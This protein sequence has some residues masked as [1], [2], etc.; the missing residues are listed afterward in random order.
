MSS[1][2]KKKHS[3]RS[4][5]LG[6]RE[7][8]HAASGILFGNMNLKRS[9]LGRCE[10]WGMTPSLWVPVV[11]TLGFVVD[12]LR[13]NLQPD[14]PFMQAMS[15]L[16]PDARVVPPGSHRFKR[17]TRYGSCNSSIFA[18]E[19]ALPALNSF[20]WRH[21]RAPVLFIQES[22]SFLVP[23][24]W[25]LRSHAF[26]HSTLGGAT[27][28]TSR[29]GILMPVEFD[30]QPSGVPSVVPRPWST[31]AHSV[32]PRIAAT[33]VPAP[34]APSTEPFQAVCAVPPAAVGSWGLF[35]SNQ[36]EVDVVLP[37]DKGWGRRPLTPRELSN[38]WNTPILLQ[39]W[40]VKHGFEVN[41]ADFSRSTPGKILEIGSDFLINEFLRGG[42]GHWTES[43]QGTRKRS[44]AAPGDP[45]C[46]P[47][48]DPSPA[49]SSDPT[50][51]HKR[52]R[53]ASQPPHP[54]AADWDELEETIL[55]Q[56]GQKRDD[57]PVHTHLWDMYLRNTALGSS[58]FPA[59]WRRG[60]ECF[61][62]LALWRWK[63]NV[64]LSFTKYM[65][66]RLPSALLANKPEPNQI[67][68]AQ[69][70]DGKITYKWRKGGH[71]RYKQYVKPIT[72]HPNIQKDLEAGR[73]CIDK[74]AH[75]T[76]WDWDKGSRPF[77]WRWKGKK[78]QRWA[79]DGQPHMKTKD[80][81]KYRQKQKPPETEEDRDL[82]W[83]KTV[84]V[85][86]R[87]YIDGGDVESLTHYFYVP[88]GDT[89][90]RM[91]YNGTSC[92]LNDCLFAPHFGL[93]T[94]R[95]TLRSL[96][97]GYCQADIDIAEMF[98]N[99]ILGEE[100]RPYSG[101]DIR[102]IR[103]RKS[104]LKGG[105][106]MPLWEQKRD[107]AWER[108]VRNWMGLRDSP[109][110][111]IQLMILAKEQAYGNRLDANN[112]FQWSQVVLN[113]PFNWEYDPALPWVFK[114]REDGDIACEVYCYVDDGKIIGR[115]K[116]ECWRAAAT[117]AKTLAYLGIQD[118][119]RK[120]TA[121]STTPGPWA[122]SVSHSEGTVTLLVSQKKWD[123]TKELV[124][125]LESMAAGDTLDRKRLEQIRGFL[126]YVSRTYKWM[127]PYLKGIH[128]TI[129]AWREGRD[130]DGFKIKK[131]SKKRAP[132]LIWEWEEEQWMEVSEGDYLETLIEE[133]QAPEMVT[134]VP[135][136]KDDV[137]A[138]AILTK[139][140]EPPLVKVRANGAL[141]ACYLMGDASGK[142]FGSALWCQDELLWESGNFAADYQA[143]S[144]N[145][146][147]ASN[148]VIR[149]EGMA[150]DGGLDGRE[151][152]LLTDN[153]V[154]EGTFYRGH[155]DSKLL[156]GLVLRVRQMEVETGCILHVIHVAG[157]RMKVAGIDGLS[158][159]DLLEGMMRS[160]QDPLHFLPISQSAA[161]RSP[162]VLDWIGSWWKGT[163]GAP[164]CGAELRHLCPNDWFSLHEMEAPRLWTPPPTAMEV[165]TALFNEDRIA[166]PHIPH[167]FAVPRLMT[168]LWR[169]QLSKDADVLFTIQCGS[170]VWPSEMH[171]PLILL[172]VLPLNHVSRYKGPW[173]AKGTESAQRLESTI[174]K[175]SK[176]W[177]DSR[178]G[179]GQLHDLEGFVP[180]VWKAEEQW[181]RNIL[182]QFLAEQRRF[183]PVHECLV[184]GL[185]SP[186]SERPFPNPGP[187][188]R[189]RRSG[190]GSGGS[191]TVPKRQRRGS[192]H[193]NSL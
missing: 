100:L 62:T 164:W 181:S 45:T 27:D 2:Q 28:S 161:D 108:W 9:A 6:V 166:R 56:D 152:F 190:G 33:P 70:V 72:V 106:K 111:S 110:R 170:E 179:T 51:P 89:D 109:Y 189:R 112:P 150:K 83:E 50:R 139:P 141:V 144:S 104:D 82:V 46:D 174:N 138:L 41:L 5:F 29:L 147:E 47:T 155:S 88:K 182:Q 57:A 39:D 79:R 20:F 192:S 159:G 121:P 118:A 133:K 14:S 84:K 71:W 163:D 132:F 187:S 64:R 98:L 40:F 22:T 91:V 134:P 115:D 186:G 151:V 140:D 38:L 157:T 129:D 142:G 52:P 49:P 73:E 85:R 86:E 193:G 122:G 93:P 180:G 173:V 183:P 58:Y 117:F 76:F 165:V 175:G 11:L 30:A 177:R 158:R 145:Y 35:P 130:G 94:I 75:A 21:H 23:D 24:G 176:V 36:L 25:V 148:L 81:P 169:K 114:V 90:I 178:N 125:E 63:R 87:Q 172:L 18:D 107:R 92:G 126:I 101:V 60:V 167:V 55:K 32:L 78:L 103:T 48:C 17:G 124:G 136:F 53:P 42:F 137:G 105:E 4:G 184:R 154:F 7:A 102:H 31:I 44:S 3:S 97:P 171:E 99:F 185:L 69:L 59:N 149:L 10:V 188:R 12:T 34:L 168:H 1:H 37:V 74:S 66:A 8:S 116:V 128:L 146:R 135:R 80:L 61:R 77:F 96:L 95:D 160:G 16:A 19:A 119:A 43:A 127:V 65:N 191:G 26:D 68:Q 54:Y 120:R 123:K 13:F 153:G 67:V 15:D 113:L 162:K 143:E 156:N 131:P